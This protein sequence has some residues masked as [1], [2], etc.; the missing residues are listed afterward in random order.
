MTRSYGKLA[1]VRPFALFGQL[2]DLSTKTQA[3]VLFC[4]VPCL[5]VASNDIAAPSVSLEGKNIW[6]LQSL[7]LTPRCILHGDSRLVIML[8]QHRGRPCF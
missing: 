7:P 5:L 3:C 6:M 8:A 2:E 4:G 1:A